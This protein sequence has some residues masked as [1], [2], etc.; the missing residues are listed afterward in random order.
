MNPSSPLIPPAQL[1]IG[2]HE[3]VLDHVITYLQKILCRHNGCHTCTICYAI[4]IQQHHAI[5]WLYPEKQYTL[6]QLS[7]IGST[8]A[9]ALDAHEYH[10]F[11]I[12][13]ADALTT[14]GSNS[15]LKSIE[16]PPTGYHFI[17]LTDRPENLVSTMLSR[18]T[19][20]SFISTTATILHQKLFDIFTAPTAC[21]PLSF[22]KELEQAKISERDSVALLDQLLDHWIGKNKEALLKNHKKLCAHSEHIIEH[23][24]NALLLPPMPGSSTLL[25]KNLFLQMR[26]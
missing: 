15:L 11:I 2:T 13:K 5:T 21:D 6:E 8:I 23:I 4:R 9:F 12:Q 19:T 7:I 16:E 25:W 1:W 3:T 20:Q 14:I 10:F 22:L 26:S 18:C 24:K 17:L